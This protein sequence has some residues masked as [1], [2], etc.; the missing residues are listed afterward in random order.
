MAYAIWTSSE[1]RTKKQFLNLGLVS[2]SDINLHSHYKE[3]HQISLLDFDFSF[4]SRL[5]FCNA[6]F[7][8]L[9]QKD[10]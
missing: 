2:D 8:G 6:V 7:I 4:S 3:H 10:C 9:P 5:D 1:G